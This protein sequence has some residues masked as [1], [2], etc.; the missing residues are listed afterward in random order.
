LTVAYNQAYVRPH[1]LRSFVMVRGLF[2]GLQDLLLASREEV[3]G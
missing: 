3:N 2:A 1:Y